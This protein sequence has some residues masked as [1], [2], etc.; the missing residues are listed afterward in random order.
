MYLVPTVLSQSHK[1]IRPKA[2]NTLK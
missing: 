1:T 2:P